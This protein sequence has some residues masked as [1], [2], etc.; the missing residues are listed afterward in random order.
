MGGNENREIRFSLPEFTV[1]SGEAVALTG[2][3]GCGK[4]TL[5]NLIA[6]LRRPDEG[7][8]CVA[9]TEISGLS[10]AA[11]DQHRSRVCGHVFQS[12]HL[13]APFTALENVRIGLRFSGIRSREARQRAEAALERVG[14]SGRMDS[15]PASLSVGERQRVAIARAIASDP[16][17]LLADEPTGSLD[18]ET[19]REIFALLRETSQ[20][21][22]RTL[23]LV[24]HDESLAA[25]LPARFDCSSLI[26]SVECK[27]GVVAV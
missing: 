16:P 1:K 13:L 25:V 24:T 23:L 8:L 14:L 10:E 9:G 18:P 27:K 2:P 21:A 26:S 3:S 12:F 5:L 19:G 17:L 20:E 22:G 7:S 11:M 6:G 15:R 4:S